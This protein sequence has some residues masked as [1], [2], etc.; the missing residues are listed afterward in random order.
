[1]GTETRKSWL[2]RLFSGLD[3]R[4][5][6]LLLGI[7]VVIFLLWNTFLVTPLKIFVVLLHEIS[8]G[9]AAIVTG[10][11]IERIEINAQQGGVCYTLGGSRF[12]TLSA[13]YLG[14]IVWG[15]AILLAAAR[16]KVDR[17]LSVGIGG[18]VLLMTL[19]YVRSTFGFVFAVIFSAAMIGMGLKL[20]DRVNDMVLRVIGLTSCLYAVLDILDDVLRRPGIGSDADMLAQ[21]TGIPSLVWGVIWMALAIAATAFFLALSAKKTTQSGPSSPSAKRLP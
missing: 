5:V 2:I 8:H 18:F 7:F 1:M 6:A 17:W 14:S 19:L 3:G 10:G 11:S 20:S 21:A 15:G 12:L 13:G 16:T 9:L 4:Q